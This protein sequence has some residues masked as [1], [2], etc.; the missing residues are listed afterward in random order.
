MQL[1]L[2]FVNMHSIDFTFN[3]FCM[4]LFKTGSIDVVKYCQ[5]YFAID[6][7]SCVFKKRQD[8]FTLRYKS[9]VNNFCKFCINLQYLVKVL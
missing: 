7:P 2:N 5:N 4:K 3:R 9:T 6:L 1:L 8:T